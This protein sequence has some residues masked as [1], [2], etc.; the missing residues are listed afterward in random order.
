MNRIRNWSHTPLTQDW[1]EPFI[2]SSLT[3]LVLWSVHSVP[4]TLCWL[5]ERRQYIWSRERSSPCKNICETYVH[6]Y[7]FY[8][9]YKYAG[10]WYHT[11]EVSIINT[12]TDKCTRQRGKGILETTTSQSTHCSNYYAII[13]TLW[14]S[15]QSHVKT[16]HQDESHDATP[17]RQFAVTSVKKF[18]SW[19]VTVQ[20]ADWKILSCRITR[21]T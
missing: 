6:S 16:H 11:I 17:R 4:L 1:I 13:Y 9:E 14:D 3:S 7:I 12:D 18:W 15:S 8:E 21:I 5:T 2:F 20:I 10:K 19:L